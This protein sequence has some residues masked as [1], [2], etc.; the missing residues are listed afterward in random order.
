[1]V[2]KKKKKKKLVQPSGPRVRQLAASPSGSWL[3][4]GPGFDASLPQRNRSMEDASKARAIAHVCTWYGKYHYTDTY[5]H[6]YIYIYMYMYIYH[7]Q[8]SWRW[9]SIPM[10]SKIIRLFWSSDLSF[11]CHFGWFISPSVDLCL[12]PGKRIMKSLG[13]SMGGLIMVGDGV[14]DVALIRSSSLTVVQAFLFWV[15]A[16][17]AIQFVKHVQ[18]WINPFVNVWNVKKQSNE[19]ANLSVKLSVLQH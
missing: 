17:K 4:R 6:K 2:F 14:N 3:A 15:G 13:V 5:I 9:T 19:L 11:A 1:M 16:W 8:T 18:C 12:R 7:Q 10:T